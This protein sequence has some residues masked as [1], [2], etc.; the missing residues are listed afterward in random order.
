VNAGDGRLL[1]L[2]TVLAGAAEER[3]RIDGDGVLGMPR[4][5]VPPRVVSPVLLSEEAA[6]GVDRAAAEDD[7]D[8]AARRLLPLLRP[9]PVAGGEEKSLRKLNPAMFRRSV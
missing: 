7:D 5:R 8:G 4:F 2:L 3:G 9:A 1:L 6:T